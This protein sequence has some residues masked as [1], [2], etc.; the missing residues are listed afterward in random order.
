MEALRQILPRDTVL[1]VMIHWYSTH[2]APGSVNG[3]SEWIQFA[4]CILGQMGYDMSRQPSTRQV[5]W[6]DIVHFL[7][8]IVM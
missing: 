3:Q 1:Q 8:V 5:G 7:K 2:N 4:R 6:F